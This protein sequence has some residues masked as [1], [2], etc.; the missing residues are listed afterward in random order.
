MI[1]YTIEKKIKPPDHQTHLNITQLI[2][3]IVAESG[4]QNGYVI[5]Q[6]KHTTTALMSGQKLPIALLVQED[7]PGF[8]NDLNKI[9]ERL[10]PK[11]QYF[12][13]DDFDKRTVNIGPDERKNGASHIKASFLPST[14]VL[15]VKNGAL[16]LGPWQS[17]LFFDFDPK[18]RPSRTLIIQVSGLA[19]L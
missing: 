2:N 13:H 15:V 18:G 16:N 19:E 11:D 10:V 9:L 17:I 12:E 3:E 14:L 6:T 1:I 7:E 4:I 5:V 8:I